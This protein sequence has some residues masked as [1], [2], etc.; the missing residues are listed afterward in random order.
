MEEVSNLVSVDFSTGSYWEE[1]ETL[2]TAEVRLFRE[3]LSEEDIAALEA[4]CDLS[5][6]E[7]ELLRRISLSDNADAI[8]V[9]DSKVSLSKEKLTESQSIVFKHINQQYKYWIQSSAVTLS[10]AMGGSCRGVSPSEFGLNISTNKE[11]LIIGYYNKQ[12]HPSRMQRRF[13]RDLQQ[14]HRAKREVGSTEVA[15]QTTDFTQSRCELHNHTVSAVYSSAGV[16]II[17]SA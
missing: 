15:Q 9:L 1:H 16:S 10:V 3:A 6:I 4:K 14:I 7:L 17:N 12:G 8:V 2:V 5:S 13:A 11:A